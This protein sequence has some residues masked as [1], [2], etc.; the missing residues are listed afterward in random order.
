MKKMTRRI[1]LASALVILTLLITT[2]LLPSTPAQAL[3]LTSTQEYWGVF[4]GVGTY[5]H[6]TATTNIWDSDAERLYDEIS[7]TWGSSHTRL[8]TNNGAKKAD[9]LSSISWLASQ[10]DSNDTAL[11][12]ISALGE[13]PNHII[14]YDSD[15]TATDISPA[16]LSNAINAIHA[17]SIVVILQ[18]WHAGNFI[19]SLAGPNRVIITSSGIDESAWLSSTINHSYFGLYLVQAFQHFA[20]AD[21]NG[22]YELS[23]EEVYAYARPLT[24]AAHVD[25]HPQINDQYSGDLPLLAKFTFNT[26]IAL[27]AGNT[28]LTLDGTNYNS[29]PLPRL[30]VPGGAHSVVVPEVIPS[31]DGVRYAFTGWDDND[32]STTRTV[33]AGLY[34][35]NFEKQYLLTIDTAYGDP[36]GNTWYKSG[37]TA[38]FSI[39]TYVETQDT[40]HYFDGWTGDFTGTDRSGTIAMNG[41]KTI[42]AQWHSEY[43][44]TVD[45]LWGNPTGAGWYAEGVS[46]TFS[47]TSYV[48]TSD[49]KSYFTGWSGDYSGTASSASL[50]MNG[51]KVVTAD[52]SYEYLLTIKSDYGTPTGAGWYKDGEQANVS[53]ETTTGFL[54]RHIFT[55]WTGDLTD[56]Q[57]ASSINMYSPKVITA[58]WKAD[59]IQLIIAIV[60]VVVLVVGIILIVVLTRGKGKP[61]MPP[62]YS[63]PPYNQPPP[64]QPPPYNQPP[65]QPPPYNPPPQQPPPPPS[66]N[67]PPPPPP[68]GR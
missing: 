12:F 54:I 37:S 66:A 56:T 32:Y 65:Q 1:S 30:W 22:D 39:T 9:V 28:I 26:N 42:T 55:G 63:Q 33:S 52:W 15:S 16:E 60:V 7:P 2:V 35:A 49:T 5:A 58:N 11:F 41:P 4:V 8:L 27:P 20:D 59:Y 23:A 44:L 21:T 17:G 53:V 48:E 14:C 47:V 18:V 45:S 64:Q 19:N 57:A 34:I 43:Y 10:A 29:P 38:S 51:P 61:K 62:P 67:I 6:Y 13:D 36:A 50:T 25:Q 24:T 3:T 68:P 40:K 46:V 31:G